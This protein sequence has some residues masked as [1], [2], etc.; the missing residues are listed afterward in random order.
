MQRK[1][2]K[3]VFFDRDGIVNASPGAGYVERWE[4]FRLQPEFV[5]ALRLVREAGYEAVVV[6]N[7]RGVALG[8]MSSAVVDDM[9]DRLHRTL[10]ECHRLNLL[11]VL[12][13]PHDD[14]DACGCRKPQPGMLL[15][16]ARRHGIDLKCSW[17]IGDQ[18]RD[19]E[20]GRRAGCRTILVSPGEGL[21]TADFRVRDLQEL[22]RLLQKLL[23]D[24]G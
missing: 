12:Y 1:G 13:C 10:R 17:M 24:D 5:K 3:C 11:D 22:N 18:E 21:S 9:H 20:A 7:Q 8:K 2:L 19:I 16:A 4:D 6:S 23:I 15:E 14:R